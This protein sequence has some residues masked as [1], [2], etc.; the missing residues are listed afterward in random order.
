MKREVYTIRQKRRGQG[1][2][3]VLRLRQDGTFDLVS[4]HK[5]R[6][7]ALREELRLR[8]AASR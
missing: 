1:P 8:S 5:T 2:W 4:E 7:E 6:A 3:Q